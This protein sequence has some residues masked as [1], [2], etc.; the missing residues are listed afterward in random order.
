MFYVRCM[1]RFWN[2]WIEVPNMD[3]ISSGIA[4]H[5]LFLLSLHSA[6]KITTSKAK[7]EH[8]L[9]LL[10]QSR[11]ARSVA[12]ETGLAP[13]TVRRIAEA[14]GLDIS[15]NRGGRPSRLTDRD[16]KLLA[17]KIVNG[18]V[19]SAK[20]GAEMLESNRNIK[21]SAQTVR[22]TLRRVG[23]K[24]VVKKKKPALKIAH[25]KQ[26]LRF[27]NRYKNYTVADWRR[28]IWSDETKINRIGSD[29]RRWVWTKGSNPNGVL[30]DREVTPTHKFGGGSLMM[31]GCMTA[32]GVGKFC[33]IHGNMDADL[34]CEILRGEL[35]DTLSEQNL[36]VSDV[37][38]QQDNDPKHT[39]KKA[40]ECLEELELE[41]LDW[42]AQSPDL[43]PI[44]HLWYHLKQQVNTINPPPAGIE[45]LWDRVQQEWLL[46]SKRT[47]LGLID[48]MPRRIRAVIRAKGGH[49]KY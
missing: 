10:G 33:R 12:I 23:L 46:I 3:R 7:K 11:S 26:R 40:Q 8:V 21:V 43:N 31:W 2:T 4:V 48:S 24:A 18:I 41:T 16:S 32:N 37:I 14:A 5:S 20:E 27:A 42:P 39:S 49:I 25:R 44:E 19:Q 35:M 9:H 28:V 47:V 13:S 22:R 34:Y 1:A 30:A 36:E 38:F 17:R 15:T 6:M 45:E 29:G